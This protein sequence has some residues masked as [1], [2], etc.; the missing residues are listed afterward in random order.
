[1]SWAFLQTM[2]MDYGWNM[3]YVQVK[4]ANEGAANR[5]ANP[6]DRFCKT[7]GPCCSSVTHRSP[8]CHVATLLTS[9]DR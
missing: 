2:R 4:T 1:M 8:S 3:S 7:R 5:T 9:R 6:A